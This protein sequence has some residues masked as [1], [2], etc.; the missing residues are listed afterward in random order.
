VRSEARRLGSSTAHRYALN[1]ASSKSGASRG[2]ASASGPSADAGGAAGD[3]AA[4][5]ADA[6]DAATRA[7]G[8]NSVS[9]EVEGPG[10]GEWSDS[11]DGT[12]GPIVVALE[13][14]SRRRRKGPGLALTGAQRAERSYQRCLLAMATGAKALVGSKG[15]LVLGFCGSVR[16][17]G[18]CL[19]GGVAQRQCARC[20]E[21]ERPAL[22]AL[23]GC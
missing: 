14:F 12:D 8:G 22:S 3:D 4:A 17:G 18:G 19:G 1:A 2:G 9:F 13:S 6:A 10:P 23:P 7:A 15:E 5:A 16:C 21:A 11:D 20:M